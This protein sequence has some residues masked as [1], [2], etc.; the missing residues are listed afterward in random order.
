MSGSPVQVF[1]RTRPTN[2]FAS[3]NIKIDES[4]GSILITIPKDQS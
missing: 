2:N 4:K 1:I 3:N